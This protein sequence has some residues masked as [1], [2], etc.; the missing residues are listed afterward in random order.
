MRQ[1]LIIDVVI[2]TYN[3]TE[4]LSLAVD[5]CKKQ[6]YRVNRIWVIDDGSNPDVVK[7][8]KENFET[9]TQVELILNQHTGLPGISREIGITQSSAEWVAF[10]DADDYWHHNKIAKQVELILESKSEFIYTNASKV[11]SGLE[12]EVLLEK[13]P[14]TLQFDALV[15][16]NWIVNSSVLVRRKLLTEST[17]YA[18]GSRVR[19][20][21]D[22]ATWLRVASFIDLHGV[23]LPLTFYR[24]TENSIRK[25]DVSDP[26]IHAFA[27]YLIWLQTPR[28]RLIKTLKKR[29]KSVI[30]MIEKQ[31]GH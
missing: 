14:T 22:F 15:R 24:E 18:N 16:T 25:D 27:D 19:A 28:G 31:Y 9:D 6:T 7:W 4:L 2:P 12:R 10:L 23:D 5:S 17:G 11:I 1:S 30:K 26:R 8:L 20:V 29:R 21:E 3:Q 13:M